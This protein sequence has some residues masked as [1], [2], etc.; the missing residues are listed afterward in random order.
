M[1]LMHDVVK[2]R[3]TQK[4][5]SLIQTHFA[6]VALKPE[7][8]Y[9]LITPT[10]E[11]A[12]GNYAFPCF[13]LS[14]IL[15]KA[16]PKIAEELQKL[17]ED[18][19]GLVAKNFGPYLNFFIENNLIGS[20]VF[21]PILS[22]DYFK[23]KLS[24]KTPKTMIEY[25]Q[26]NTHK[27]MHVGHMRNLCLGNTLIKMHKYCNYNIISTTYP[28]DM[29]TH[30][31]KTLWYLTKHNKEPIPSTNKGAWLGK[32]YTKAYLK[33]EDEKGLTKILKELE[34]K[35]SESYKLW[36]ETREWSLTLMKDVYKW[37][38]VEFDQWYFESEVDESSLKLVKE[39]LDKGLFVKSDGA[40][41][42]DLNSDN[43][44]FC[45]LLKSDGHGLYATKDLELARRKFQDLNIDH[46]IYI[47][48][49]RQSLH[50][51]QVFKTLEYMG[52][53]QAKQCFHLAYDF[54]E[55]P[56]G[57]MSSRKGNIVPL[58]E[59]VSNMQAMIKKE[60]LDRYQGSWDETEI[61][62]TA[63]TVALGA[64]NYGMLKVDP[65][66]KIVFDMKE[67]LKLDGES[68]PYLQYVYARINSLLTKMEAN[69]IGDC[70]WN[71][72]TQNVEKELIFKLTYFNH[73]VQLSV[74]QYKPSY[75]CS[76]LYDVAKLF[77]H[78]YAEC[79]IQNAESAE[80]KIARLSL[81]KVVSLIIKN[82][83]A[84]LGIPVPNRM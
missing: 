36:R 40:V 48:D 51:K 68:G 32:V 33:L 63:H 67:W 15:K 46:S 77:N 47:V 43:L 72:L 42:M 13:Q 5:E 55:L 34:D 23:L 39:Y 31:A 10:P 79:S 7:E 69:P 3:I 1:F 37:A 27:E 84:L 74:E 80:I 17:F 25:S 65:N 49:V 66:K 28:G 57:A 76:Y 70:N 21:V 35:N 62:S 52:F 22:G 75:L 44:G 64:I 38:Q 30:V 14:K 41:G 11:Q 12:M 54:V 61:L 8:I 9:K 45:L 2:I 26:P 60:Y 73:I 4:L 59:L 6:G 53:P 19:D 78:F 20:T 58:Q 29:G 71:A 18:C 24:E 83:L 50:F 56:D 16:P 81:A 82:G